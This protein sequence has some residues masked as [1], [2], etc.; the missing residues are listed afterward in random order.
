MHAIECTAEGLSNQQQ[1]VAENKQEQYDQQNISDP[2]GPPADGVIRSIPNAKDCYRGG[3]EKS[4]KARV[5]VKM[6]MEI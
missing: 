1:I 6:E 4:A 3:R 5:K 2:V